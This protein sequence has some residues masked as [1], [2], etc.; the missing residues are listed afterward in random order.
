MKTASAST[1]LESLLQERPPAGSLTWLNQLRAKAVDRVG[2]LTVPTTRDEDWRFTETP[3][4][5][6]QMLWRAK[7]REAQF[8]SPRSSWF[9]LLRRTGRLLRSIENLLR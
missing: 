8:F 1:Y 7:Y 4:N 5:L 2:A 3:S 9:K 6:R